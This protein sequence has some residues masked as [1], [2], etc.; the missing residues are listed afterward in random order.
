MVEPTLL[1]LSLSCGIVIVDTPV[2]L[3]VIVVT[4]GFTAAAVPLVLIS[5]AFWKSLQVFL[6][7]YILEK[8]GI[9]LKHFLTCLN[10]AY[11]LSIS[12]SFSSF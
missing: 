8:I 12:L 9:G 4:S 6:N 5:R 11:F 2:A 1:H 7:F 3:L 10:G